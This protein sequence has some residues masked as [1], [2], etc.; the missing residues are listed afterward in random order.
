MNPAALSSVYETKPWGYADQPS[1]LNMVCR[2]DTDLSPQE[3]LGEAQEVERI[4]GRAPTFRYGPRVVDVDIL[5]YGNRVVDT[6]DLRV[7]HPHLGERA[8]VLVPLA[9]IAP[10]L[11]H[12]ELGVS[13]RELLERLPAA[14]LEGVAPVGL[15]FGR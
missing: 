6:Q 5:L 11:V 13:I 7:P 9:E 14:E 3:L 15:L 8:F 4:L 1:F 2:V 10:E 12:P